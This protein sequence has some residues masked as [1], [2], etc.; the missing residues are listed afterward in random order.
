MKMLTLFRKVFVYVCKKV[1]KMYKA[2]HPSATM[3]DYKIKYAL[4]I[5]ER[6]QE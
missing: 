4:S 3:L 1:N 6:K 2:I 5:L